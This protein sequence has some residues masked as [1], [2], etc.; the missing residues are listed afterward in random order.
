VDR[1]LTLLVPSAVLLV[2]SGLGWWLWPPAPLESR[3]SWPWQLLGGVGVGAAL[4]AGAWL[5]ERTLP[6]FRATSRRLE[7]LV[8]DLRLTRAQALAGALASGVSEELFF[9][10]WLLGVGGLWWQALVFMLLHPAGRRGWSYTLYTGVAGLVLGWL[11]LAS[12]SLW[13][14]LIAHVA[15]NLHGLTLGGSAE[16]S[17]QPVAQPRDSVTQGGGVA[18]ERET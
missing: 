12:G 16:R 15:V 9:R 10:G 5:L 13:P 8:R 11:T 3:W 6:S 1:R 17:I 7:R 18:H 14:A 2:L 4:L